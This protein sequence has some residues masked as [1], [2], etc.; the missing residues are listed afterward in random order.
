MITKEELEKITSELWDKY[1]S[2]DYDCNITLT[3]HKFDYLVEDLVEKLI[4]HGV[5]NC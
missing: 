5:I 4:I 1:A 2:Q 3:D